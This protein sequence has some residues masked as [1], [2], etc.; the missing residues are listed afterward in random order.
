VQ[1]GTRCTH[2]RYLRVS[3]GVRELFGPACVELVK[4]RDKISTRGQQRASAPRYQVARA[5]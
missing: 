4:L 3:R 5:R 1:N 2:V